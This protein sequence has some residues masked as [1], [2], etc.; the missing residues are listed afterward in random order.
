MF[1]LALALL[2]LCGI[3]SPVLESDDCCLDSDTDTCAFCAHTLLT[4]TA[5][6]SP[7]PSLAV[8]FIVIKNPAAP[9]PVAFAP[10]APPPKHAA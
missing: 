6:A 2:A 4:I 10:P 1:V 8:H 3:C 7:T 9:P 5:D